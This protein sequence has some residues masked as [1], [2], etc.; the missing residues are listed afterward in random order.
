MVAP[1]RGLI[2][3]SVG[4]FG[5]SAAWVLVGMVVVMAWLRGYCFRWGFFLLWVSG[6]EYLGC[7]HCGGH[8]VQ[9]VRVVAQPLLGV[10][11][12]VRVT[13]PLPRIPVFRRR[14]HRHRCPV[15]PQLHGRRGP[16]VSRALPVGGGPGGESAAVAY[17]SAGASGSVGK[18]RM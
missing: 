4:A 13:Q 7:P 6:C 15:R 9:W 3:S 1:P 18:R 14:P 2:S 11:V 5:V 17:G 16:A 10:G 8:D 12:E